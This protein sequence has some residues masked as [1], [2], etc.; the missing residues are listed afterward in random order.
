MKNYEK[1]FIYEWN[2]YDI[3]QTKVDNLNIDP[4]ITE[5]IITNIIC[6]LK[7]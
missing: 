2:V 4:Y 1:G 5:I 6:K 3:K 7:A